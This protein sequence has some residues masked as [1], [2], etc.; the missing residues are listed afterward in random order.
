MH[1]PHV[2]ALREEFDYLFNPA[3]EDF[4]RFTRDYPHERLERLY[5]LDL[6]YLKTSDL[7]CEGSS[8]HP[9]TRVAK[10]AD[11]LLA[12][13][14]NNDVSVRLFEAGLRL[15]AD[16]I[17]AY[18]CKKE[19]VGELR[20]YPPVILIFW[21]AFETFVRVSVQMMLKTVKDVPREVANFLNETETSL[22][23]NGRIHTTTKFQPV[24]DRYAA[25]LLY[26]YTHKVD[27]GS[28]HWQRLEK[29]KELR[30][31]YTHLDVKESRSV[32]S[33]EI[34]D[35]MEAVLLG[36]IWPS[37]ELKRT[38]LLRIYG[39]YDVW[40]TLRQ[41][42]ED[43]IE[44]PFHKDSHFKNATVLAFYC[45]FPNVDTSEFPNSEEEGVSWESAS[46]SATPAPEK[47]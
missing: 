43:F 6:S 9:S 2:D 30:D 17:L 21:S 34:L 5:G 8:I 44:Q 16:S 15:F 27:K 46:V 47:K 29:A 41:R 14:R 22:D 32:S 40:D 39:L 18:T 11:W 35:F 33:R 24:L 45:P 38:Q 12:L 37:S 25:L 10:T 42:A 1:V 28:R 4:D 31:Y 20:Y 23:R 3:P 13:I 7:S 36:I 26:G 19:R